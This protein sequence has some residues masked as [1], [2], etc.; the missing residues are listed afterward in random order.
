MTSSLLTENKVCVALYARAWVEIT[1][2][3]E[4]IAVQ[5]V[6]LYARVWVEICWPCTNG[7]A[8]PVTLCVKAGIKVWP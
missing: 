5:M 3:I 4:R 6:A 8:S 1:A 2:E 7:T